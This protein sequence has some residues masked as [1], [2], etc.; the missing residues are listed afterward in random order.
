MIVLLVFAGLAYRKGC[1]FPDRPFNNKHLSCV[2][3]R[4]MGS[5]TDEEV[6]AFYIKMPGTVV[7]KKV[8]FTYPWLAVCA[9]H[10]YDILGRVTQ[11]TPR[12]PGLYVFNLSP[13]WRGGGAAA[14]A[15]RKKNLSCP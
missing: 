4:T 5:M 15:L 3:G 11:I 10:N 14:E 1:S 8:C 12:A 2:T 9:R 6:T 7:V 13:H